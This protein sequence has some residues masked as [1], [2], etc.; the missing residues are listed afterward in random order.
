MLRS[1]LFNLN[2]SSIWQ[3]RVS[4]W[5]SEYVATSADRLLAL[6]LHRFGMMGKTEKSVFHRFI[7]PNMNVVD[8]GANQ[9]IYSILFSSLVGSQGRVFAFEPEPKLYRALVENCRMNQKSNIT[10][11]N[12]GL[13]DHTGVAFLHRSTFNSG[14]NRLGSEG[15]S[16]ENKVEVKLVKLDDIIQDQV[17]FVKI[18]VQGHELQVLRGMHSILQKNPAIKIYFEMSPEDLKKAGSSAQEALEYFHSM[19]FNL[20]LSESDF[21]QP[22]RSLNQIEP[23]LGKL[24]YT[25]LLAMRTLES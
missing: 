16:E 7:H 12:L 18:D 13:S 2:Q 9:G 20:Y 5:G 22:I 3:R 21:T 10:F 15:G 8:I 6:Y 4:F 25:N 1:I 24:G 17:D 19:G 11:H 14:D 23:Y